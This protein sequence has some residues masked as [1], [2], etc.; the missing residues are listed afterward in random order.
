MSFS[1]NRIERE[2][3]RHGEFLYRVAKFLFIKYRGYS[4][5]SAVLEFCSPYFTMA[6]F[7]A[8]RQWA[9]TFLIFGKG[10]NPGFRFIDD[11][12][13]NIF[14]TAP[15]YNCQPGF[16]HS[17]PS[18]ATGGTVLPLWRAQ[19]LKLS[20]QRPMSPIFSRHPT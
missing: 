6:V 8:D 3:A 4:P 17:T 20:L 9:P 18:A 2:L 12:T 15:K 14:P 5:P 7:T 10:T 16:R 11:L 13:D 19:S 1:T